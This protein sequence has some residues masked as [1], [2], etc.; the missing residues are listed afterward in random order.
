M[1]PGW[2]KSE[3]MNIH[4]FGGFVRIS[5]TWTAADEA[6]RQ[7]THDTRGGVVAGVT[8]AGAPP[9]RGTSTHMAS[10]VNVNVDT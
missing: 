9:T 5:K 10:S 4:C 7:S 3:S 2:L 1:R 6:P 8:G